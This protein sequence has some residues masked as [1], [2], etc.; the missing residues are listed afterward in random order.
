MYISKHIQDRIPTLAKYGIKTD[1]QV[2]HFLAQ[3]MHESSNFTKTTENL[4]YSAKG[5]LTVFKKYF[6]EDQAKRYERKPVL[7]ASRVYANRMGNG[8]E[9][10]QDGWKYR[11]RGY[12]GLTFYNNYYAFDQTVPEDVVKNPE[13]VATRFPLEASAFWWQMNNVNEF[14]IDSSIES[15]IAVS[16]EVNLG[17][18]YSKATPI[19]LGHRIECFNSI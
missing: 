5:L 4:N 8:N 19:G 16:K 11:G 17:N 18:G 15:I 3:C 7:I 9:A 1:I 6:N 14:A 2:R 10:S 12:I 13:L